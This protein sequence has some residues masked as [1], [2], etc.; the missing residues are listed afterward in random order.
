MLAFCYHTSHDA[1]LTHRP[2]NA[3]G[4]DLIANLVTGPERRCLGCDL[5]AP[6][7]TLR[8]VAQSHRDGFRHQLS[9]DIQPSV[10]VTSTC[11]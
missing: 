1:T 10:Q 6:A 4:E 7:Q 9:S 2:D 5:V 11:Q 8:I 3:N